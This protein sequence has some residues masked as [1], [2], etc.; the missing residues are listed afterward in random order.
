VKLYWVTTEDHDEDWFVVASS[1]EEASKFHE[2]MEGYD[3]GDAKAEEVLDIPED[4]PAE[5]GW[6]SDELLLAVGAKFLLNDQP[7]MV[8]IAGRKFCE[9]MLEATLNEI[10]EDSFEE[11]GDNRLNKTKKDILH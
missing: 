9:G 3:P 11:R 6:P 5:M 10:N 8:E 7:R 4:V 2:D 1:S